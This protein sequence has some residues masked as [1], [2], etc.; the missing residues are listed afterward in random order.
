MSWIQI[1]GE[2]GVVDQEKF[3]ESLQKMF[4]GKSSG[5]IQ[6]NVSNFEK[7]LI[8]KQKQL[9]ESEKFIEYK[10]EVENQQKK[11]KEALESFEE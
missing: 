11:V 2:L 1:A 5:I 9:N 4:V 3:Q 6:K 8:A 7:Q 10:K